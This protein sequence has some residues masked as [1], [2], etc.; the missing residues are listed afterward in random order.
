MYAYKKK[1]LAKS[2]TMGMY[3]KQQIKGQCK[4]ND[5]GHF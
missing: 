2:I 4:T 5:K 1:N 3:I